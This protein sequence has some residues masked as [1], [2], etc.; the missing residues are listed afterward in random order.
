[1][2]ELKDAEYQMTPI[3]FSADNELA[4]HIKAPF[5]NKSFFLVIVGRPGSGKT[6]FLLNMLINKGENR[7]YN[8]VYDRICLVMPSNSRRSIENDPFDLPPDQM[9][10]EMGLDVIEKVKSIRDD[11]TAMEKK[12]KEKK[13]KVR[14]RNQLLVMDDIT[15]YLKQ[16]E[17]QKALIELA[18]NRRHLR[19][20]IILLVQYVKSIPRPVR[21][22]VTS[23]VLFKPANNGELNILADEFIALKKNDFE[24]L[25]RFVF[26]EPHDFLFL[27]KEE[28]RY[29]K[30]LSEI[31]LPKQYKEITV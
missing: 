22:Q 4:Q 23:V 25:C 15:A 12:D 31:I 17:N 11:F 5:P 13:K 29:F 30:N 16:K 20:S 26:Q 9:F 27:V 8:K 14:N 3:H 6:T 18:T 24:E 28:E 1:M 10:D 7:I 19:L 2:F 21:F